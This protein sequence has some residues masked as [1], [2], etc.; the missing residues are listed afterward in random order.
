[1]IS[2][3]KESFLSPL[4]D[5][6]SPIGPQA[7]GGEGG[8]WWGVCACVCW[9]VGEVECV[10]EIKRKLLLCLTCSKGAWSSS[11][12]AQ[13]LWE[14]R[15]D[16]EKCESIRIKF[17]CQVCVHLQGIYYGG[18]AHTISRS[19]CLSPTLC[20]SLPPYVS[21][22][23]SPRLCL[24]LSLFLSLL[25]SVSLSLCLSLPLSISDSYHPPELFV[26]LYR[27]SPTLHYVENRRGT[28]TECH[29]IQQELQLIS[30]GVPTLSWWTLILVLVYIE[31]KEKCIQIF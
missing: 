28:H 8:C 16:K 27:G 20:L 29:M 12:G 25:L 10:C 6:S 17:N 31:A 5:L 11:R 21:L 2:I 9:R 4:N 14:I 23:L 30:K 24:S 15:E 19:L 13:E 3:W 22:S 18:H 1:M 26:C 7:R